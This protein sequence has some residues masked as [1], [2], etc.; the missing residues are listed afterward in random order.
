MA[1]R[2][3]TQ[4]ARAAGY[5][6]EQIQQMIAKGPPSSVQQSQPVPQEPIKKDRG[7]LDWLSVATSVG[8]GALGSALGPVGTI[9]GSAAGGALGELLEQLIAKDEVNVGDIGKEAAFSGIGGGVGLGV[10]KILGGVSGALGREGTR[11][12]LQKGTKLGVDKIDDL[13]NNKAGL[14]FSGSAFNKAK[15]AVAQRGSLG[16]QR[17]TILSGVKEGVSKTAFKKN[18]QSLIKNHE[19]YDPTD[20]QFIRNVNVLLKKIDKLPGNTVSPQQVSTYGQSLNKLTSKAWGA[21]QKGDISSL[22][23][24]Q[25]AAL[26]IQQTVN[27]Y[28]PETLPS[29]A[30]ETVA[31][32]TKSMGQTYPFE[33]AYTEAAK[34][35]VR[36]PV[37]NVGMGPLSRPIQATGDALT[38]AGSGLGSSQAIQQLLGQVGTRS[39]S[40]QSSE[41]LPQGGGIENILEGE[42][43]SEADASGKNN[44]TDL[45]RQV[46]LLDLMKGGKNINK[47][48]ALSKF[49]EPPQTESQKGQVAQINA[50][51]GLIDQLESGFNMAQAKGQTGFAKGPLAGLLGGVSGGALNQEATLY[52]SIRSGFT[53]LIA[54]ATGERGVLTDADAQRA[55]SLIPSLNDSPG[56]AAGKIEQIR[57]VFRNAQARIGSTGDESSIDSLLQ[58]VQ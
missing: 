13:V 20:K 49:I 45:L 46:A 38:R 1:L 28:L 40:P 58:M 34:K 52:N 42:I 17:E 27:D 25:K 31:G 16:T 7:L 53:A 22:T 14:K 9:G 55:L 50:A 24:R 36:I 51:E 43:V 11:Q 56:L 32:I 26:G 4:K 57:Q 37:L 3:N 21:Y 5:T 44:M 35:G 6:E 12:T 15:Q 30:R 39:F 8:G 18:I 23:A 2:F 33:T 41:S 10:G 29:G 48:I 19:L 54:R 47:I